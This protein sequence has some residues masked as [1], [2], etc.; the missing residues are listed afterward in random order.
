MSASVVLACVCFCPKLEKD[1]RS[2]EESAE[3]E[4]EEEK[5]GDESI[6]RDCCWEKGKE[7]FNSKLSRLTNICVLKNLTHHRSSVAKRTRKAQ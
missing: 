3:E 4:E 5:R 2:D 6:D 7:T 1:E